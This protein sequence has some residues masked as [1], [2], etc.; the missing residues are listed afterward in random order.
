MIK[1][2]DLYKLDK[3]LS[4]KINSNI[5]QTI[6]NG[7]FILGKKVHEFEKKF[8]FHVNSKHTVG[9]AN[10]TD[11]LFLAL[12]CLK[13]PK[14]SEVIVPAMTWIS[15]V[16]AIILN[17]LKPV[18]VD[19][20]DNDPLININQIKKKINSKTRVILP[21]HLYGSVVSIK[22]IKKIIKGKNIFIIDDAAQA[23]GARDEKGNKV[24]SLSD[25]SCFSFY[26]GKNLGCYGDG[27]AITTNNIRFYNT[28]LKMR[29]LGSITKHKHDEI[30]INSRLDTLQASILIEK[31]NYL[32][33]QN[34]KRRK[35][36]RYYDNN[37]LNKNIQKLNYS[38]NSVYHQY[39][40]KVKNRAKLTNIFKKNNIQYG[41]HYP[42]SI[43]QLEC[44]KNYFKGKKFNNAEKL[45]KSCI[46]I[47]IDPN[48]KL[49][50][51]KKI[52]NCVNSI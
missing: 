45:A 43:N 32:S 47:P 41:F 33:K 23:H 44:F 49:Q 20:N 27:G 17:N 50:E 34:N 19:I 6:K 18:L 26:P 38:K 25:L 48:L 36:A 11:A 2:L 14:N 24:G 12:K 15:T 40:I 31:L 13:L 1:F 29:N 22:K 3:R 8:S 39:V 4:K 51:I 9:C 30:G 10:G 42:K 16:L 46:S 52:V 35:I 7:D 37:I 28:L 5:N 21:V